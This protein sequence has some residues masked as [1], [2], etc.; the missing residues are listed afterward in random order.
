M[1]AVHLF[2]SWE[3]YDQLTTA[4]DFESQNALMGTLSRVFLC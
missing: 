4:T 3:L 2:Y 1:E